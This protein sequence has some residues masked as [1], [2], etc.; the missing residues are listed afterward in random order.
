L[1][2]NF[3]CGLCNVNGATKFFYSGV[4]NSLLNKTVKLCF[5]GRIN[6]PKEGCVVASKTYTFGKVVSAV[7]P[8]LSSTNRGILLVLGP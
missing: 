8:K 6:A 1:T 5:K 2:E 3:G 4:S 7:E